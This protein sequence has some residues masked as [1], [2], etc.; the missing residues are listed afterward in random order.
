[1]TLSARNW[2]WDVIM[3]PR[4]P[5]EKPHVDHPNT[6]PVKAGEKLVLLC[7]A[8]LENAE[9][10]YSYPSYEHIAK[11]TGLKERAVQEHVKTLAFANAFTIERRRSL[12]GRWHRNTYVLNVPDKYREKDEKWLNYQG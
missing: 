3:R 4:K 6:V 10:G 9:E 2:A 12:N 1:M 8:E 7:I 5:D 11:R